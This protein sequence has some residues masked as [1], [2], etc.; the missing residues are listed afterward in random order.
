MQSFKKIKTVI[1]PLDQVNVDTDQ[2]ID[3]AGK[4]PIDEKLKLYDS[5]K[6][7][8]IKYRFEALLDKFKSNDI[9]EDEITQIVEDV[10][11]ERY[12]NRR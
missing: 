6:D 2:I 4:M 7:D 1:T 11:T 8:I 12:K 9:S 5:I 10:R 3:A